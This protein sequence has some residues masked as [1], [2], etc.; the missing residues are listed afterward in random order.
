MSTP[1]AQIVASII[2]SIIALVAV[3]I[4]PFITFRASKRQMLGPMRQVWINS[5]RDTVAE[6]SAKIRL[7]QPQVS[8]LLASDDSLRH[9]AQM[10]LAGRRQEV[11]QLNARIVLLT[12]PQEADHRELV[13]L[14][15]EALVAFE[16]F[17]DVSVTLTALLQQTQVVLK[18][19]WNVV[20]A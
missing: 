14:A 15:Q 1:E 2:A 8:A 20:K 4:G 12:N 3:V 19:E 6:F 13:R 16:Q 10:L 11:V 17:I 7:G 9:Q 18:R 5:L